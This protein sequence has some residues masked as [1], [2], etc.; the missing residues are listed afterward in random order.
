MDDYARYMFEGSTMFDGR[1]I[2]G[3]DYL[4]PMSKYVVVVSAQTVAQKLC[5]RDSIYDLQSGLCDFNQLME[6]FD[7]AV[8]EV[9]NVELL[10]NSRTR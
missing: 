2:K 7:N 1:T 5:P 3:F 10:G 4:D 6:K 9:Y 8:D